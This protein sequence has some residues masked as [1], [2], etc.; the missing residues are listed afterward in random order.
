[1]RPV[2]IGT[3]GSSLAM[4]QAQIVQTKLEEHTSERSF[5]LKRI[6]A[7]A[8]R[9]PEVQLVAMGGEGIFVKELETALLGGAVDLAVHSLKD[10]PLD[11]P[12]GLCVGAV[13]EREEPR[14]ALISRSGDSLEKLPHGARVGTSSPRRISQL[15]HRRRDLQLLDIRG[16][17]DTRLRKLDEGKYDAIVVAACGLI[18]LGLEGRITECLDLYDMLPEPG[19]GALAVEVRGDDAGMLELVGSLEDPFSRACTEAERAFL[20]AMGGGCRVPIAAYASCHDGELN[21]EGAVIA[22]DGS[23]MVRGSLKG[24]MTEPIAVGGR[25]AELLIAQG[26]RNLLISGQ[27]T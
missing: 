6:K 1:M 27:K 14:D 22:S 19:Q 18:R 2:V 17:V 5:Q 12:P 24:S 23:E 16:N 11:P 8:D 3:R 9:N 26:A 4:C 13:L 25:L 20:R 10:L 15:L 7:Q 21:L